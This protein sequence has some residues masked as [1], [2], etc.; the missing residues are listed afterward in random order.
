MS[1][2]V[3]L[4]HITDAKNVINKTLGEGTDFNIK[5]KGI[6]TIDDCVIEIHTNPSI[7]IHTNNSI[8]IHTNDSIVN[9]N[10]CYIPLFSRYYFIND[11]EIFPNNIYRIHLHIDVLE[12]YKSDI[13]NA[14]GVIYNTPTKETKI[15]S[16]VT[17]SDKEN[18][19]VMV[20]VGGVS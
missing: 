2:K 10:Y 14:K 4:Y 12:T 18:H 15:E 8:E 19:I 7:E 16:N 3:T 11:I 6:T 20:T 1:L 13:L 9:Y 5:L 17:L